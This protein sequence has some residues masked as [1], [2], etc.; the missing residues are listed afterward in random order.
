MVAA[1]SSV[2]R[3]Y[4]RIPIPTIKGF[5]TL[6]PVKIN[7]KG[8]ATIPDIA[9]ATANIF[10]TNTALLVAFR[11]GILFASKALKTRPPS[12]GK[13]GNKLN[14]PNTTFQNP[15]INTKILAG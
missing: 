12:I 10:P 6:S 5:G 13:A 2:A 14:V 1:S 8:S 4:R 15:R 11:N 7:I 3:M 9:S